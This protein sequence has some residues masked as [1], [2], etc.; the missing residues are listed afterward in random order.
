MRQRAMITKI[1]RL[2]EAVGKGDDSQEE[3]QGREYSEIH[4]YKTY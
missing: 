2:D 4:I 3:T 1:D